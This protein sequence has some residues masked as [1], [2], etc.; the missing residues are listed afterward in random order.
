M[1]QSC[2][3]RFDRCGRSISRDINQEPDRNNT[4]SRADDNRKK[5][6]IQSGI[7]AFGINAFRGM[8]P[9]VLA[10]RHIV[11]VRMNSL[12]EQQGLAATLEELPAATIV[13]YDSVIRK[14]RFQR[15]HLLF[16]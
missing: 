9:S 16:K 1:R 11:L 5:Q 15:I 12:L 4:A 14:N 3:V 7:G 2:K 6:D 13:A 8:Q 10:Q